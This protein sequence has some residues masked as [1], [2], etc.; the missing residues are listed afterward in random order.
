[1]VDDRL[2]YYDEEQ[3]R[4][5]HEINKFGSRYSVPNEDSDKIVCIGCSNT[6]GYN[7]RKEYSWP[8]QLQEKIN[9]LYEVINLGHCGYGLESCINLY[10]KFGEELNPSICIVQPS[11]FIR[12]QDFAKKFY[13][14]KEFDLKS[15]KEQI[16]LMSICDDLI[17]FWLEENKKFINYLRQSDVVPVYLLYNYYHLNCFSNLEPFF[18]KSFK[19]LI[20]FLEKENVLHTKEYNVR[21]FK[22]ENKIFIEE[23]MHPNYYG[24]QQ[25]SN[26]ISEIILS[27]PKKNKL[28][29]KKY[30][31][32]KEFQC[33]TFDFEIECFFKNFI[34]EDEGTIL[35]GMNF[36]LEPVLQ[37]IVRNKKLIIS[38]HEGVDTWTEVSHHDI[39]VDKNLKITLGKESVYRL[40]I[41]NKK[42]GCSLEFMKRIKFNEIKYITNLNKKYSEPEP[43][44]LYMSLENGLKKKI[45]KWDENVDTKPSKNLMGAFYYPWYDDN[46]L[47]KT[48]RYKPLLGEYNSRQNGIL[49]KHVNMAKYA[50]IDYFIASFNGDKDIDT[51]KWFSDNLDFK[52]ALHYETVNIFGDPVRFNTINTEKLKKHFEM[53]IPLFSKDNYLK[54]DGRPVIFIYTSRRI[55]GDL[56]E[57]NYLRMIIHKKLQVNPII[58]G[59]EIWH[60]DE[61]WIGDKD[62]LK[63]FDYVYPYNLYVKENESGNKRF[64]GKDYLNFIEPVYK[65][66]YDL[67]V[68]CGVGLI[69]NIMP[70]Y[71][72]SGVRKVA[73]HYPLPSEGGKFYK[74]YY[75]MVKKFSLGKIK[76]MTVTSFNEWYEDTQIE[77]FLDEGVE[78]TYLDLTRNIKDDFGQL[79]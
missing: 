39:D 44:T 34:E 1:M 41:N 47:K 23:D 22:K 65:R 11:E 15:I 69:P 58:I 71:N 10:K 48:V 2:L 9:N 60:K 45:E 17:D 21:Q 24:N 46:W 72:D 70:R 33:E 19:K 12:S 28:L 79:S 25:F 29:T 76:M 20:S 13:L 74:E 32:V 8:F 37:F 61:E 73:G 6:Y 59:D 64:V 36:K 52:Y 66:F 3:Y 77:P 42:F 62:R 68:E 27:I 67:C 31:S 26:D 38:F 75:E 43:K 4:N 49:N 18:N 63:R 51:I 78:D 40:I 53:F 5:E 57:I 50:G 55:L 16:E 7:L 30:H 14:E 54:I 56:D 35:Y